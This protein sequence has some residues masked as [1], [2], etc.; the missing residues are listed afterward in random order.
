[1]SAAK[2][3]GFSAI[4]QSCR[5]CSGRSSVC[6]II[7]PAPFL[8]PCPRPDLAVTP[9]LSLQ[10]RL[11]WIP[12][13]TFRYSYLPATTS[14]IPSSPRSARESSLSYKGFAATYNISPPPPPPPFACHFALPWHPPSP[15]WRIHLFRSSLASFLS[16]LL[17]STPLIC[18]LFVVIDVRKSAHSFLS[19]AFA[20][21]SALNPLA[22]PSALCYGH[23]CRRFL[24]PIWINEATLFLPTTRREAR[25]TGHP[26]RA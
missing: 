11:C 21:L 9:P 10:P 6:S 20:L 25:A 14:K 3:I 7:L 26:A 4:S 18:S 8:S 22:L 19:S 23:S 17:S 2:F 16:L 13:E 1:M 15:I 24:A 12:L 5:P